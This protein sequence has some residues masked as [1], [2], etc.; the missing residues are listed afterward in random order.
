[1]HK[2]HR[3]DRGKREKVAIWNTSTEHQEPTLLC[4][5]YGYSG[6]YNFAFLLLQRM[7]EKLK[8]Q[9]DFRGKT[10]STEGEE[11]EKTASFC[12]LRVLRTRFTSLSSAILV[13]RGK[14]KQTTRSFHL[15]PFQCT[16][17]V[18][19]QHFIYFWN[20]SG[21]WGDF[22]SVSSICCAYLHRA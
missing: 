19:Y 3:K 20:V 8:R 18:D 16:Q 7:K 6:N 21:F 15:Y 22:L 14:I 9:K 5:V 13:L 1:M 2:S 17:L 4:L 12:C 11:V 10:F